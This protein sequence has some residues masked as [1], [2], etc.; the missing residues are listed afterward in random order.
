MFWWCI[1][2]SCAGRICLRQA[3]SRGEP[4]AWE[5]PQKFRSALLSLHDGERQETLENS[6]PRLAICSCRQRKKSLVA[7]SLGV[8]C[9]EVSGGA[10][11]FA[12]HPRFGRGTDCIRALMTR[13]HSRD[14]TLFRRVSLAVR[15]SMFRIMVLSSEAR[16]NGIR[17]FRIPKRLGRRGKLG[18]QETYKDSVKKPRFS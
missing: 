6:T 10:R 4:R 11:R 18:D 14:T 13:G 7:I 8:A 1:S 16:S 3:H 9:L 17:S 2:R 15:E 12:Y 5:P